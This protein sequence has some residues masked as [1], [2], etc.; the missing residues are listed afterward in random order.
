MFLLFK[1]ILMSVPCHTNQLSGLVQ[2][3]GFGFFL[4]NREEMD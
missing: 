1:H 4:Y 3:L 2:S